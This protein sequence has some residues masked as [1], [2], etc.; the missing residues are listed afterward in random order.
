MEAS[1]VR[2]HVEDLV[3]NLYA[4][5]IHPEL[6]RIFARLEIRHADYWAE[7]LICDAG[8]VTCFHRH[9]EIVSELAASKDAPLPQKRRLASHKIRGHRNEE[10]QFAHGLSFHASVQI[11]QVD[12]EV[13]QHLH[14]ELLADCSGC[15]L[16][17]RFPS[18]SRLAP[19]ALSL[20]RAEDT[21]RS[22][23]VHAFHTYP[24]NHA[25]LRVQSLFEF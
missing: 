3:Y 24:D 17:H 8:H 2:P 25:V 18:R 22:L 14:E 20:I 10:F 9:G 7:L 13:Y 5:T 19:G 23:L 6:F 11:E 4:R 15:R 16:A 21:P 1:L 12:G